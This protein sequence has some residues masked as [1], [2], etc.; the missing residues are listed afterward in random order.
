MY[1]NLLNKNNHVVSITSPSHDWKVGTSQHKGQRYPLVHQLARF[2]R[3]T[4]PYFG[5]N[6]PKGLY[7]LDD[8]GLHVKI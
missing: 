7:I 6:L 1:E 2:G 4:W 8:K 5:P 3:I